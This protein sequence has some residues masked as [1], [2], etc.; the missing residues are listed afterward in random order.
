M[1]CPAS[2]LNNPLTQQDILENLKVIP[3]KKAG[4]SH[5]ALSGLVWCIGSEPRSLLPFSMTSYRPGGMEGAHI[6]HR[7]GRMRG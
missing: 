4:P 1:L 6:F 3:S 7:R 2:V 5:I